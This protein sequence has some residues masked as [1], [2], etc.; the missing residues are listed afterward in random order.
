[1][2]QRKQKLKLKDEKL[3]EEFVASIF[4]M[5]PDSMFKNVKI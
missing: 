2:R 3:F 4:F 5:I 1:M